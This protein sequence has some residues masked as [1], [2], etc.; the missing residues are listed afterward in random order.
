MAGQ[1]LKSIAK[2]QNEFKQTDRVNIIDR[3]LSE[4]DSQ[5]SNFNDKIHRLRHGH[6]NSS[7]KD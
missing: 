5:F 7:F 1:Q 3:L 6:S 4:R 2:S